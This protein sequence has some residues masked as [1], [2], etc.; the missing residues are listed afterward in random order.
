MSTTYTETIRTTDG[1]RI[2][3]LTIIPMSAVEAID[4][5]DLPRSLYWDGG[6]RVEATVDGIP[7]GTS[8]YPNN[9]AGIE[10]R[11]L[12]AI[13]RDFLARSL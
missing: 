7:A 6:H 11:G 8:C 9:L 4:V 3:A 5:Y 2:V 13:A 12:G 10:G 1:D